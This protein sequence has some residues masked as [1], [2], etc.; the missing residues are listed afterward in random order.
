VKNPLNA[1]FAKKNLHLGQISNNMFKYIKIRMEE[2]I[3]SA[4]LM[5]KLISFEFYLI[6]VFKMQQ[7]LS[8]PE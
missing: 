3:L 8:I 4:F 1:N 7:E 2:T 6:I 5:G